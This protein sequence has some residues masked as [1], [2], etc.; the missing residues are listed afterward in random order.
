[1]LVNIYLALPALME[2]H[3]APQECQHEMRCCKKFPF[4]DVLVVSDGSEQAHDDN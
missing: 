4:A 3:Y 1:M 2:N